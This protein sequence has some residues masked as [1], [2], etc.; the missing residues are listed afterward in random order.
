MFQ[1]NK[2][3]KCGKPASNKITRIENG[4][5]TDIFLCAEHAGEASPYMKT[6]PLS[7]ILEGF[8]KKEPEESSAAL[9]PA[10]QSR[11]GLRCSHCGLPFDLYKRS[12]ILGCSEC[13]AS[14]HD[15]LLIDLRKIHG[16]TRNAGAPQK[17]AAA[18]EAASPA[19]AAAQPADSAPPAKPQEEKTEPKRSPSAGGQMLLKDPAQAIGELKKA[20]Q[21]AILAEDYAR[22][23][24]YRDQIRELRERMERERP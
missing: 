12:L 11:P 16:S 17:S 21:Q 6:L 8:L 1:K 23:A 22:A 20:M 7:T 3:M 14:F 5:V 9:T 15:E 18:P 19:A 13:Y 2:C 4:Q 10:Q 24:I